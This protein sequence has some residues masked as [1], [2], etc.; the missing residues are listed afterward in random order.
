VI[1]AHRFSLKNITRLFLSSHQ[2]PEAVKRSEP[3]SEWVAAWLSF[4]KADIMDLRYR[5]YIL[6][7]EN[8]P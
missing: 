8:A 4:I 7:K 6:T 5:S 3:A 2:I 1:T